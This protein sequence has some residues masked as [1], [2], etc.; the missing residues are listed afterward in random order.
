VNKDDY[1]VSVNC[2]YVTAAIML[3]PAVSGHLFRPIFSGVCSG[4]VRVILSCVHFWRWRRGSVVRTS[5]IGLR[6]FP[7]LRLIY[8]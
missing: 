8:D 5:V 7:D 3:L 4:N 6:T 2:F 1:K